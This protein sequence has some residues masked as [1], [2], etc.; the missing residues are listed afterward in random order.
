MPYNAA[1]SISE[2]SN[3]SV[4]VIN[5]THTGSDPNLTGRTLTFYNAD[6]SV[7][8]TANWPIGNSSITLSIL[9]KDVAL[10]ISLSVNSSDPEP[11][12]S[13][14]TYS[15]IY[16]FLQH[17]KQYLYYLTQLQTENPSITQDPNYYNNKTRLFCEVMSAE[18]AI[19]IGE[20]VFAADQ[21]IERANYLVANPLNYF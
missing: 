15:L 2:S 20:D 18:N 16:A 10:S 19:S 9:P 7:Y 11:D 3:P 13:T 4:V 6:G 12:P 17:S 1:F 5:D 8:T 14:Y 21:C